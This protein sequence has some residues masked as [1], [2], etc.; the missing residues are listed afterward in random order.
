MELLLERGFG[1]VADEVDVHGAPNYVFVY[2]GIPP[3]P[4]L[5]EGTEP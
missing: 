2:R 4:G 5:P 3:R 1:K